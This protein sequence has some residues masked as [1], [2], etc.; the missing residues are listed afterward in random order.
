MKVRVV[1]L[2]QD[3]LV[4]FFILIKYYQI[5]SN[6]K[7]VMAC[8][9]FQL[10]RRYLHN[11]DSESCLSSD[12]PLHS[13]QIQLNLNSSNTRGS[14]TI[15]NSNSFLSPCE[16]LLIAQENRYLMVIFLFYHELVCCVYS[17]E[18]PHQG[19]SNEYTQHTII[20]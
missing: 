16:I 9:I 10:Q 4:F 17:L 11:E 5:I 1:C 20:V 8:K 14:F 19:D 18:S 13:C 2:A 7:G 6:S 3:I 15:V 12:P